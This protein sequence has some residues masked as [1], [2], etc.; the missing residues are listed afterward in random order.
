MRKEINYALG[1]D[2]GI[3]S[4]GWS[5]INLDEE[6]IEDLGVRIFNAAEHPKT[7]ASLALPRR[8]AR[9]RRRLLRRKAYRIK[10][11]RKLILDKKILTK[12]QL[13]NLFLNNNS[14]NVWEARVLGL[15]QKLNNEEWAKLLIN[16]CKRRGFKSNRKNEVKD[17]ESGAILTSINNNITAMKESGARTIGEYIFKT[18]K[19][20]DDKYKPLRNK[21][22]NYN[23]CVS[24]AIIREEIDLLFQ[25]QRDFGNEFASNEIEDKYLEIFDSQRPY[26][27]FEDLEKL[28]GYCTFEKKKYKRAPKNSITVEEFILY[29]NINKISILNNGYKRKLTEEERNIVI[30]EAFAK[31]EIKYSTLRKLLGLTED[32]YFSTLTYNLE[33]DRVKTEN[34]KFISL[35]GYHEIKKAIEHGISKEYWQEIKDDRKLL[36]NIAYVLTLGKTDEE[37]KKQLL[38]RNVDERIIEAVEDISFSKFNNLSI[39]ALEKILPFLKEGYQYSEACEKAGY[40]FKAIYK[41]EKQ[42]KLPVIKIDEIVNP[43]VNRALAQT[44][45]VINAV[46]DRYGSPIRINIELARELAKNFKDRKIIEKEQKENRNN[47]DKIRKEIFDIMDREPTGSEVLKYRLWQEQRGECAYSQR[48]ISITDLFTSGYCEIDHIIP[49]SKSFDDSLANKVLVLTV[50]NQRKGNRTPYEYLNL[51]EDRWHSFEVW[52]QGSN[53]KNRKKQ[54]LLKKS[55]SD[56]EEKEWKTRNLQDTKYICRYI[57]NFVNSRLEFKECEKHSTKQK[58]I[59]VNGR[60]TSF[61]RRKWGLS[62]VREDGDKHHALDATVVAVTTQSMVK[63]I[64]D[65]SKRHELNSK[66]NGELLPRPWQ[67]F[68]EEL[69]MRLSDDPISE[70]R[71]SPISS[72]DQEFINKTV[73]P[74]FVSRVPFRKIGGKLFKE[75]VYSKRAFN[76]NGFII[77]KNLQ[78]VTL[79]DMDNV[80]N[81][82]GDRRLYDALRERLEEFGGNGKKAFEE[83][84][85]KPTKDGKLGP[86]VKS[87]KIVTSVPF[88]DGIEL[89][90]GLVAKEGMVRIDIYEKEGKYYAVPVYRYQLANGIIP[91]KAALASKPEDQWTLMDNSYKFYFSIYKNDLIEIIFEKKKD[92][93][94][95]Y[96]GFDRSTASLVM[97]SHDSSSRYRGIGIKSGVKA[98]NKYEVDVLGRFHKVRIGR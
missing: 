1:L 82:N 44:R 9:G 55:F 54:N 13:D 87:I 92:Y 81:Y 53:L 65:F 80:Y 32:D 15:D 8:E 37:I 7:G 58:V 96:D 76:E 63:K 3:T 34:T 85:R 12:E 72:Y 57:S 62:K 10:R 94:G 83:E 42:H 52:V 68:S 33:G 38:K 23:M 21:S 30:N 35:K 73:R 36:N 2:I 14:I 95:Y 56:E 43:V 47:I 61:L 40:D 50:E 98:F 70:L 71:K 27:N 29:E 4:V 60:A 25:K 11:V 17:K 78:E 28:V 45:K 6:R 97:E 74:I 46:I 48:Q 19:S 16:F 39:E 90:D 79:K 84:F 59:T 93:F 75:T 49:F 51:N 64:S 67:G 5:I 24:R 86:V 77:K 22:G 18:V 31:K 26:S 91:K 89:N 66:K 69:K 41:G 20:D 88:K